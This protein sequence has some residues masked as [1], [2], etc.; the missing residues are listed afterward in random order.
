MFTENYYFGNQPDGWI[1]QKIPEIFKSQ[2]I[3]RGLTVSSIISM[4][5]GRYLRCP[6]YSAIGV[7]TYFFHPAGLCHLRA[8]PQHDSISSGP[9]E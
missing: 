2:K 7:A 8:Y 3:S 6:F 9:H 4:M 1:V 5:A